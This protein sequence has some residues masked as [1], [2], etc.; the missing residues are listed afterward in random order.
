MLEWIYGTV[1]VFAIVLLGLFLLT[2]PL[3]LCG[4]LLEVLN[5]Y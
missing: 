3:A 4:W 5:D 2:L 1:A